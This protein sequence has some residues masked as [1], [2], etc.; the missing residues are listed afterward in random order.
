ML[1]ATLAMRLHARSKSLASSAPASRVHAATPKMPLPGRDVVIATVA[2]DLRNPLGAL[3]TSLDLVLE[4]LLPDDD[5]LGE[6]RRQLGVARRAAT[7]MGNLVGD[8]LEGALIES[9][10]MVL[11]LEAQTPADIVTP[12]LE[13]LEPL[14]RQR[15]V[16]VSAD[17]DA[18]L[19]AIL[20]DR[21][22]IARVFSNLGANAIRFTPSGGRVTLGAAQRGAH[23][24]FSV[25]DTGVGIA[26]AD[27]PRVFDRFWRADRTSS[28]S[29]GLGLAIVKGIVEA[30]RGAIWVESRLGSGSSFCFTLPAAATEVLGCA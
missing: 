19:P 22:R 12:A 18:A 30:H 5:T 20:A 4:T 3:Q 27:V 9:G 15:G 28:S 26:P 29:T 1:T 17:I 11:R 2:H 6:V 13:M 10:Q 23:V 14:A 16:V 7:A 24:C 25:T 8:L 21:A